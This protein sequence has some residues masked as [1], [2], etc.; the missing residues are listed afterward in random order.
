MMPPRRA[1]VAAAVEQ[2][3]DE[4]IRRMAAVE[5]E[6]VERI[7]NGRLRG[8][9]DTLVGTYHAS[10]KEASHATQK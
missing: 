8:A 5:K 9:A 2:A 3:I 10:H 1:F 7:M 6:A 4:D